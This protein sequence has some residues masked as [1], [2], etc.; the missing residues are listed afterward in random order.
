MGTI[1]KDGYVWISQGTNRAKRPEHVLIAE[2]VLGRS[3][4]EGAQVHHVDG[5]R[6]NNTRSNLVI[7]PSQ[8]YHRLL[9]VRDKAL[10]EC[11]NADW[12]RCAY[13]GCYSP[14][15]ELV[16]HHRTKDLHRHL[17]CKRDYARERYHILKKIK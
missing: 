3:L 13:C 4:P 15:S 7:C 9:H 11:G 1:G 16:R 5:N 12:R 2:A 8:I 6:T 10:R 17:A 14:L